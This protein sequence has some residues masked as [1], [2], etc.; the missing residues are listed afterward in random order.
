MIRHI[1]TL[2]IA[3]LC[4]IPIALHAQNNLSVTGIVRDTTNHP[5]DLATIALHSLPDSAV[6]KTTL[7]D[8]TGT[9]VL[10][11]LKEGRYFV[12]VYAMD[13][14]IYKGTAVTAKTADAIIRLA[15][16]ILLRSSMDLKEVQVTARKTLVVHKADRTVVNVDALVSAAGGTALDVLERSP[17]LQVDQNGNVTMRGKQGVTIYIDDR[18]THLS[19]TDLANY[20]KSLPASAL[21]QVELMPNP[22]ANYDAAGN[23]GIINI[24]MKKNN[25]KGFNG[26]ISMSINQGK[27]TR[28]NNSVNL[29]Y[30]NNKISAYTN[31]S[32]GLANGFSDLDLYRTYKNTDNTPNTFF[33]QN[34]YFRNRGR[35]ANLLA[36][37]DYYHSEKTTIGVILT[38]MGNAGTN[39]NDNTSNLFNNLHHP[40]SVIVAH[41]SEEMSFTNAGVNLNY[42]RKF[43]KDAKITADADY[44]VY[45]NNT[46]QENRSTGY[47]PPRIFQ[48]EDTLRGKLPSKIDI[49]SFKADYTR[50]GIFKY[51]FAAGIKASL[52]QTDNLAEYTRYAPNTIETDYGKSNHFLYRE[53]INAAYVNMNREI[54]NLSAQ[55]GLRLE[56]TIN[57]GHQLGNAMKSDSSFTNNYTNLF[58]TFYLTYKFDSQATHQLGLNYGRRIDRPYYQDLNP[59]VSPWDKFTYYT[60]N[61]FLKPSFNHSIQL[62]HTYRNK[63]TTMFTYSYSK[64]NVDETIR[65]QNGIY[66]SMPGNIGSKTN[67]TFAVDGDFDITKWLNLH[68]YSEVTNIESKSNFYTGTLYTNGAYWFIMGNIRVSPGKG[69]DLLA[70]G[71]LQSRTYNAQF[72]IQTQWRVNA[73]VQ[74]KLTTRA[75]LKLALNDICYSSM[76]RGKIGNLVLADAGWVNK[77]DSRNVSITFTYRFGKTIAGQEKYEAKGAETEKSRVKN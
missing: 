46:N 17:G 26:S 53:N 73:A 4:L 43:N 75:T 10:E 69:W 54:G 62:S 14:A 60:G 47:L 33:E 71:Y 30:R 34:T 25:I 3:C 61:P 51:T 2:T 65:I 19:G 74:K 22:P 5:I 20:L 32:Y 45:R 52:T 16:V 21:D 37:A 9:F 76:I 59:F 38:A 1:L 68:A 11:G 41:N 23:G 8:S 24:K 7:T 72:I 28:S 57:N 56:N 12:E 18:P 36:G 15:P 27:L 67:I 35:Y 48:S 39:T 49:Y 6:V 77:R 66:Y 64:D 70:D 42:R 44:L 29:N 50:P 55:A 13:Y 31:F 63:L 40:D 58:P